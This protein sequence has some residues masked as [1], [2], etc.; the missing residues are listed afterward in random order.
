MRNAIQEWLENS[1]IRRSWQGS[2]DLQ[3]M[4][5]D[6]QITCRDQIELNRAFYVLDLRDR[7]SSSAISSAEFILDNPDWFDPSYRGQA[8]L[9]LLDAY[10]VE[11]RYPELVDLAQRPVVKE[12]SYT[13]IPARDAFILSSYALRGTD[14]TF[15]MLRPFADAPVNAKDW[16]LMHFANAIAERAGERE[17]AEVFLSKADELFTPERTLELPIGLEGDKAERMLAAASMAVP[18]EK[19]DWVQTRLPK[20]E[21]PQTALGRGV[22]GFCDVV[23]DISVDGKPENVQPYCS[24]NLILNSARRSMSR[25]RFE[26]IWDTP[27]PVQGVLYPLEYSVGRRR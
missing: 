4:L 3:A 19:R 14:Q 16:W 18:E 22:S 23:F 13:L 5:E 27:Q 9:F 8:V 11:Q 2:T 1:E 6:P 12:H 24:S 7:S 20:P 10:K 15:E 25:V 21:Y 17:L 26:H